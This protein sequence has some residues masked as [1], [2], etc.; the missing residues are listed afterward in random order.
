VELPTDAGCDVLQGYYFARPLPA[1]VFLAY[2]RQTPATA[3]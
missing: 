3:P 1:E 2:A